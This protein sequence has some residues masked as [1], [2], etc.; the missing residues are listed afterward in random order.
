MHRGW[1][2]IHR[3]IMDSKYHFLNSNREATRYEA[4]I[5]LIMIANHED[6]W[7]NGVMCERGEIVYAQDWY[8]KRWGWHKSKV[9]RWFRDL[10]KEG[11]LIKENLTKTTRI[12][13]V[14]YEDYQ[15]NQTTSETQERHTHDTSMTNY[16]Q[17]LKELKN[18]KEQQDTKGN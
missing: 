1:I 16:R 10:E 12:T 18:Y 15:N 7:W 11:S 14:K 8:A 13:I 9:R 4:W 17:Q 5:D 6:K 2:K 3:K